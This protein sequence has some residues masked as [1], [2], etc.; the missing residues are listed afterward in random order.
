MILRIILLTLLSINSSFAHPGRTNAEGCHTNKATGEYHCHN[1]Q[2][3]HQPTK[4]IDQPKPLAIATQPASTGNVLK[5]DYDGFT[6]WLDC[7]K[8]GAVKFQYNAQHDTGNEARAKDF[9]FDPNV[10][11]ACQQ[12]STDAYSKG[13]DRGHQLCNLRT[14]SIILILF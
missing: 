3:Q 6:V 10:P 11:K 13:Y 8:R 9:K 7:S 2:P 5:L 1:K 4:P 12:T 14:C